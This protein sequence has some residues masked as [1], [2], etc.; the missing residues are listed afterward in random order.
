M[1]CSDRSLKHTVENENK[2][3]PLQQFKIP[4]KLFFSSLTFAFVFVLFG[5]FWLF[6]EILFN[7]YLPY[8][9][10]LKS[11]FGWANPSCL[12]V[13]FGVFHFSG[14]GLAPG[15][16][17]KPLIC[18][19]TLCGDG[20]HRR[21]GRLATDVSPGWI[22]LRKKICESFLEECQESI[23]MFQNQMDEDAI[24]KVIFVW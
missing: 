15:H 22:F 4:S 20:S 10:L 18:Q 21:R 24:A 14:P 16:W 8:F 3:S 2:T 9:S 11:E 1:L 5:W 23:S 13:K 19:W 6:T 17:P 7:W 12:V